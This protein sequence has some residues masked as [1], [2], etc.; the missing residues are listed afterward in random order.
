MKIEPTSVPRTPAVRKA[1]AAHAPQPSASRHDNSF[2]SPDRLRVDGVMP[3]DAD[4]HQSP[5]FEAGDEEAILS[6]EAAI[7]TAHAVSDWLAAHS[8][9][10]TRHHVGRLQHLFAG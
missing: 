9:S 2:H 7:R 3:A 5:D 10:L 1:G 6:P 4:T 8:L